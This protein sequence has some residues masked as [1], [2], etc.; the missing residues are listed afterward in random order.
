MS[1]FVNSK[2][3]PSAAIRAGLDDPV[4]D[5]DVHTN[6]YSPALE[7][8]GR[9]VSGAYPYRLYTE[10]NANFFKGTAV[11]AKLKSGLTVGVAAE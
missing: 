1:A 2:S 8:P 3:S 4:I 10:S 7:V 6:D 9:G 11:E 5:T